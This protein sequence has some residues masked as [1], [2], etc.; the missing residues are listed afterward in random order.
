LKKIDR[1]LFT[2]F[3]ERFLESLRELSKKGQRTVYRLTLVNEWNT[4]DIEQYADL[5]SLGQPDF[6]ELK[7]VTYCGTSTASKLSMSNVPWHSD[8]VRFSKALADYLNGTYEVASE[9]E[10]SNCVLIANKKF[11]KN[12]KWNTWID[13]DRFHQLVTE[14]ND[15][16]QTKSFSAEDY[17][18]ET[19]YWALFSS[20]ERGFDPNETRW[21]RNAAK[22]NKPADGGC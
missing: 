22:S 11:F 16:G 5:V 10:H 9:H 14:Y 6:I 19:P 4:D 3:W 8:V 21:H 1:P 20:K 7:G 17:M 2:D 18:C 13:Y 12:N 15:S